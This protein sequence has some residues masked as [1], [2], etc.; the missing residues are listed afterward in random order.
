MV[1]AVT[2]L[3]AQTI[4]YPVD[5]NYTEEGADVSLR[6]VMELDEP[7][8][9]WWM[10]MVAKCNKWKELID[11][12]KGNAKM[13]MTLEDVKANFSGKSRTG[14]VRPSCDE[15]LEAK[16]SGLPL[17]EYHR[18]NCRHLGENLE[19]LQ[20]QVKHKEGDATDLQ[21]Q[22]AEIKEALSKPFHHPVEQGK[23]CAELE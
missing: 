17:L 8:F 10:Q 9:H 6:D 22:I 2:G 11:Q 20:E 13:N 1:L 12:G 14:A 19:V 21:S 7:D 23:T 4:E 3:N 5:I 16:P 15:L 18:N